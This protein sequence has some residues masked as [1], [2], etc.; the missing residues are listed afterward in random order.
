MELLPTDVALEYCHCQL[1]TNTSFEG[2]SANTSWSCSSYPIQSSKTDLK[3]CYDDQTSVDFG[4]TGDLNQQSHAEAI[5]HQQ[6]CPRT[7]EINLMSSI[8]P[9]CTSDLSL[10]GADDMLPHLVSQSYLIW[11]Q[12]TKYSA[13]MTSL[14]F[15]EVLEQDIFNPTNAKWKTHWPVFMALLPAM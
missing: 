10:K 5:P 15:L 7:V 4:F 9:S 2:L 6:T 1:H 8:F 3:R 14:V 12:Y 11:V 13:N